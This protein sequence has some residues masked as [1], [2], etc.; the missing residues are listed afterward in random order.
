MNL[1]D[2]AWIPVR[3]KDGVQDWIAPCQIGEPDIVALDARRP[4]FNGALVQFLIGLVQ[5]TTPM[6]SHAEWQQWYDEPPSAEVLK[7]WFTPIESAFV[8]DGDGARFM[9]DYSL[10]T[11]GMQNSEFN[12]IGS[13]LIEAPGDNTLKEN[14]DHFIKRGLASGL[15]PHCAETALFTLQTNAPSGGN[16]HFTSLRG[17]GPLTTL[18]VATPTRSLWH[19]IWLNVRDR[20]SFLGTGGDANKTALHFTF[21][22]LADMQSIQAAGGKTV[23]IQV[24]P[25]HVFWSMPRRIRLDQDNTVSGRCDT[26]GR[27]SAKLLTRYIT[28]PKGFNYKGAWRHPLSPYYESKPE[29]WLPMHPQPGGLGYKL[30][31]G[32]V[33]GVQGDKKK[34]Q[35]ASQVSYVLDS[36]RLKGQ[37]RLWVFGYDMENM[38][39][40]CWYE[41]TF[42]LYGLAERNVEER[43]LVQSEV[44]KWIDAADHAAFLLR[45]AVRSAWFSDSSEAKGDWGFVDAAFWSRTESGFYGL[46]SELIEQARDEDGDSSLTPWRERWR[47]KLIDAA[48]KLF[49]AELVGIALVERQN[50][51]RV[52]DAHNRLRASLYGDKLKVIL[53]LPVEKPSKLTKKNAKVSA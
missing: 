40:R 9:Q 16:G 14:K 27:E 11:A 46:L 34:T 18:I 5:T 51:R 48:V 53:R 45:T 33:L 28:R 32:W 6:N 20:D 29:E 7:H 49:D 44:A 4:D 24:H 38:K 52:A 8:F 2:E 36:R 47:N 31:L 13:L 25:A 26:C 37:F 30:W 19:T 35:P 21:P 42:P 3:R 1:L 17:G 22:W 41:S 12:E 43:K 15:C 39:A 23:P 10:H 50:P